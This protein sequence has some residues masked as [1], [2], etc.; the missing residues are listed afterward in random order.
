ML[1]VFLYI[2]K[3]SLNKNK[4]KVSKENKCCLCVFNSEIKHTRTHT[5]L[6]LILHY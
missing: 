3:K 2:I 6:V 4:K 1:I 5:K